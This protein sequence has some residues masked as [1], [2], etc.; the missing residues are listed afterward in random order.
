M[1]KV[2]IDVRSGAARFDVAGQASSIQRALNICQ[3][4]WAQGKGDDSGALYSG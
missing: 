2:S 1:V 3:R 4:Q